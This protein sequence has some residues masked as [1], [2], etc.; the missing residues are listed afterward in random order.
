M[1]FLKDGGANA[2]HQ[3]EVPPMSRR[4]VDARQVPGLAP[5]PGFATVVESDVPIVADRTMTWD[6]TGYGGHSETGV[7]A[8]APTW[9]LAEGSTFAGLQLYYMIANPN[10][11]AT[12]VQVTYLR[13][14][15]QAPIVRTYTMAA[16]SRRTIWV[17]GE[18]PALT[19]ANVS[20]ILTSLDAAVPIVVERA[21]YL[22][23]GGQYFGAGHA[24]AGVTAPATD[25]FLAEGAT[26]PLFDLFVLLA[27]PGD[28]AAEVD[29]TYLLTGG[30][31]L[32]RPFR[33]EPRSRST[34]WVNGEPGLG[35]T[36][37]STQVHSTNGVPIIVERAMW[38][39]GPGTGTWREGH[40]SHGATAAGTAWAVADGEQGGDRNADTYLLVANTSASNGRVRV[41]LLFEDGTTAAQEVEVT[42]H[43]RTT[44]WTGGTEVTA[45]S[46]FGGVAGGRRFGAVFESLPV[47]GVTASVVVE[48]ATYWDANGV[49]WAA[50][51]NA[52]GTRLR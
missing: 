1:R 38:W 41:T 11:R 28:S 26:G 36:S 25:W 2:S 52:V 8:A 16:Q 10:D 34:I 20:G 3:I 35:S 50:G 31:T 33:V 18:D 15:E 40:A 45:A 39:P 49:W 13:L 21:M 48:R 4:T 30:G 42:G 14:A 6:R 12:T 46:P 43:S 24:A 17:N 22:N 9:Y 44:V 5:A 47:G 27:N 7:E 32:V 29:V 19:A 23:A 51:T 37:V